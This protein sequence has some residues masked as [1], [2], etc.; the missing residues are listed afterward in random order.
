M[1][2]A[3]FTGTNIQYTRVIHGICEGLEAVQRVGTCRTA[4]WLDEDERVRDDAMND[5]AVCSARRK[6]TRFEGTF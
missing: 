4:I 6:S 3:I 2:G 5:A 1:I